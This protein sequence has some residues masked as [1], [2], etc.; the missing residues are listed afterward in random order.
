[1]TSQIPK[2]MGKIAIFST[3]HMASMGTETLP[4]LQLVKKIL[5]AP[6]INRMDA[7]KASKHTHT[8]THAHVHTYV[9][10]LRGFSIYSFC[11]THLMENC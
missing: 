8:H 9:C 6:E 10:V 7:V 3:H 5:P 1:M 2:Y 4:Q 11:T